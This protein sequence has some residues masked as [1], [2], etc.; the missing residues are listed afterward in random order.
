MNA[1]LVGEDCFTHNAFVE[2]HLAARS[3][4][5]QTRDRHQ[6]LCVDTRFG[7]VQVAHTHDHFL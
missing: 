2:G 1:G 4:C 5:H 3:A 6:R 7:M